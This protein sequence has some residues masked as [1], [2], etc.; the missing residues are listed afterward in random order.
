VNAT[1]DTNKESKLLVEGMTCASCVRRVEK[2]LSKVEGVA[3]ATVNFATHQASVTHDGH[4]PGPKLIE[5]IEA[6]GYGAKVLNSD[7]HAMH[8]PDEHAEHLRAESDSE[9]KVLRTDLWIATILTVPTVAISMLWHPRPEWANWLLFALAT[10]ATF[11][12]GRRF[13]SVA[14]R[15]AR[16]LSATMDTLVAMGTFAAWAYSVYSLVAFQGNAHHQ[17]EHIYFETGAVI[18]TLILLGRYME[19]KSKRRMSDAIR[20]LMGLAPKV[21]TVQR[22]GAEVEIPIDQVV[23]GDML[24]VRPGERIAV[25]GEVVEG[26]SFVDESMLT[27]EPIPVAKHVG[28]RVTGGTMNDRGTLVFRADRVGSDTMLASI[29]R[30]VER[31]Q[32]SKAPLQKLADQISAIFVPIVIGIAVLTLIGYLATGQSFDAGMMAAVAV[33]VIACPCALGLATPT[34]L[35]VG[36]G[37]GAELGILV[38]DGEALERAANI[39]RVL[40]DK[41][42]TITEGKP[43]LTDLQEN[44]KWSRSMALASAA[45]VESG[46]EHPLARAVVDAAKEQGVAI[47]PVAG[48]EAIRGKGVRAMVDGLEVVVGSPRF[49]AD[50]IDETLRPTIEAWEA[51]GKT[52]FLVA[53]ED[54]A[55]AVLAV[56]DKIGESALPAIQ[57]LKSL[58]I[59]PVMVTGDNRRT[60]AAI[61]RQVGIETVEAEVLPEGKADTVARFQRDGKVAMVGDGI[62]DAPALAQADLG[63][64]M[65]A[66]TDVAL[67][68]AGVTL[69]RSNL[70]GIATAI[71]L[72]RATQSTIKAN[73]FWAF[74]YNVVMIPLAAM[75]KLNP[76]LAAAAMAM[77]SISVVLNSLRLKRFRALA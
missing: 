45:A 11:Y 44:E 36:T 19:A 42:G 62:N 23:V 13:F 58:G 53:R 76:M 77:S 43:H 14:L 59:E 34:A 48:F 68:T 46:S 30:M 72:A 18:I 2:A 64:A 25:D 52:V 9:L 74:A 28:D 10:P 69:L 20:T 24:R 66:G 50:R 38:K 70:R 5:A 60:A 35:M 7:P 1:V 22:N 56:S 49:L 8:T 31:A 15:A 27:G 57:D 65:G 40:L 55:L 26:E 47:P 41:T 61:A 16:H 71:R 39:Q 63:I 37:R 67:E 32:G 75:G 17:S 51:D 6:A 54:G 21:A 12:S 73:L 29:A 3:E 4:V 33:L